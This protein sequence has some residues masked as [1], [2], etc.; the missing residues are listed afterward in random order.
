[1]KVQLQQNQTKNKS[2]TFLFLAIRSLLIV[3][4]R[5][6]NAAKKNIIKCY[7]LTKSSILTQIQNTQQHSYAYKQYAHMK[8]K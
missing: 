6:K 8:A 7:S 5:L 3:P 2:Q 4:K 1:M